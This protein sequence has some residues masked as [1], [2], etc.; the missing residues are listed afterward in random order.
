MILGNFWVESGSRG[1]LGRVPGPLGGSGVPRWIFLDFWSCPGGVLG[2][3]LGSQNFTFML[4]ILSRGSR[5]GSGRD[6][7]GGRN[8]VLT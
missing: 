3:K 8:S 1:V 2:A 5:G 4:K 7:F 6:F